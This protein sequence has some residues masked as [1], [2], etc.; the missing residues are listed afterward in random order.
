MKLLNSL[1]QSSDDHDVESIF[2]KRVK[3]RESFLD[4]E[5]LDAIDALIKCHGDLVFQQVESSIINR[6]VGRLELFEKP[7]EI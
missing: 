7:S 4:E 2:A 5:A 3:R 1:K 6:R